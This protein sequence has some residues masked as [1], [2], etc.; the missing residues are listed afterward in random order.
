M[1]RNDG[2]TMT[3]VLTTLA[4]ALLVTGIGVPAFRSVVA[5]ARLTAAVNDLI[6]S[7]HLAR[8]TAIRRNDQVVICPAGSTPCGA[9]AQWQKG[10]VIFVNRDRLRPPRLDDDEPVIQRHGPLSQLELSSNRNFYAFHRIGLRSTNG[11]LTLC[12][13]RGAARARAV[14][15]SYTGRPRAARSRADGSELVC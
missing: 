8:S 11:T 7:V 4:L 3:E 15:V 6:T 9:D 5:D 1:W 10:W 14:I 12:D 2:M 13:R